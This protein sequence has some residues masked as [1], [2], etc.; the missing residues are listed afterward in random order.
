MVV[1]TFI[2]QPYQRA[3]RSQ[4]EPQVPVGDLAFVLANHTSLLFLPISRS[5]ITTSVSISLGQGKYMLL[6]VPNTNSC[7]ARYSTLH[8]E[9]AFP[10]SFRICASR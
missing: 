9:R 4:P 5:L 8:Q 10:R 6:T 3:S 1:L 2:I 7:Y